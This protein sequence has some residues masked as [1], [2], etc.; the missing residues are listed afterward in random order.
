MG[1]LTQL[2]RLLTQVRRRVTQATVSAALGCVGQLAPRT[3]VGVAGVVARTAGRVLRGRLRHNLLA[4]G[5]EPAPARLTAWFRNAGA[6]AGWSLALGRSDFDTSG[7]VEH[8]ALGATVER[9]ESLAGGG[10]VLL[11]PHTFLFQAALGALSRRLPLVLLAREN[12]N[13]ARAALKQ[14]WYR[15]LGLASVLRPKAGDRSAA[16]NAYL[17]VLAEKKVLVITPDLLVPA[18]R[19]VPARV[20]GHDVTLPGGFASLAVRA[21]VPV[22]FGWCEWLGDTLTMRCDEPVWLA[23]PKD[24]AVRGAVRDWAGRLDEFLHRA[25]ENWM[26]W[27][28][29][30]WSRTLRAGGGMR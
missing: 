13:P 19:G 22:V 29:K 12:A 6:W 21:G 7:L 17:A 24:D 2:P 10:A 23:G 25:P 14:R 1:T 30:S 9:L 28:D 4:A 3:A 15:A 11:V 26:F 8:V 20:L 16:R 18:D 27:L 5:V